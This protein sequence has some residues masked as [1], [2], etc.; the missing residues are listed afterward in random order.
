MICFLIVNKCTQKFNH[1]IYFNLLGFDGPKGEDGIPGRVSQS[2]F[3]IVFNIFHN[4]FYYPT[5]REV[6]RGWSDSLDHQARR[7]IL[8]AILHFTISTYLEEL[9]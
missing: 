6:H 3:K 5:F 9:S 2:F 8:M 7:V 4:I 1:C